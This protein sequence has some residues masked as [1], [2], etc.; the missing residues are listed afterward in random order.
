MKMGVNKKD[1]FIRSLSGFIIGPV[2]VLSFL[3]YPTLIGL[4][5]TIVM[6]ASFEFI[7][8]A[9]QEL[10]DKNV[11]KLFMTLLVG[12]ASL[13]YG[14]AIEAE[15]QGILPFEAETIF[16]LAFFVL[17]FSV[18]LNIK[19]IRMAKKLISAGAI[20]LL[21]ISFFLSNFFMLHINYGSSMA[22]LAL[23]S[24]WMYDAAAY[25][26][27]LNFGKHKISPTFSPK[28]SWEGFI[29]GIFGTY[30]YIFLFEMIRNYLNFKNIINPFYMIFFAI[31][32]G[33]FDT[34][35][36]LTESIF[37][38]HYNVKDSSDIL[39]GHGGLLDR[40]DGL[41]MVTPM[42]YFLLRI[43]WI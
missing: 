24:V 22:I 30:V 35:G 40:I 13:I 26:F 3:L 1:I 2:V 4:V 38:R 16:F 12:T 5:T 42:W 9:S 29:G 41:L 11:F 6:L 23:T 31:M 34:V 18:L 25:F 17:S 8:M 37:K 36:D 32:V 19:D 33:V 28:K 14:F 21:Y 27:G 7:E 43:F 39:P 15:Y 20:S 10:K